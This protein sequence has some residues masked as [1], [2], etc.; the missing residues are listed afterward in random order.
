VKIKFYFKTPD[1]LGYAMMDSF[2]N[3]EE[4]EEDKE[5]VKK[6]L[7]KWIQYQENV[8]LEYDTET[9]DMRVLPQEGE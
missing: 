5:R 8:T 3:T 4:D 9:K 6:D 2:G 7:E 1:V